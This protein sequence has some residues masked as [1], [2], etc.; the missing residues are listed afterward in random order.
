M[1]PE[2]PEPPN[3]QNKVLNVSVDHFL[4]KR[5]LFGDEGQ[6]EHFFF[7]TTFFGEKIILNNLLQTGLFVS[8]M[9]GHRMNQQFSPPICSCFCLIL[10]FCTICLRHL[11]KA[12]CLTINVYIQHACMD[13]GRLLR[14]EA[15]EKTTIKT[16]R[17]G[18]NMYTPAR[19]HAC[20][21]G[22]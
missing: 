9:Q 4:K 14:K 11:K 17:L 19:M 12:M 15:A 10:L 6:F 7:A 18:P 3:V 2:P 1:E 22:L 8:N 20:M 21:P 16:S 5:A 13:L